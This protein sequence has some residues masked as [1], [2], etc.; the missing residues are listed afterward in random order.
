[1]RRR[2]LAQHD[3]P[4][5]LLHGRVK[6]LFHNAAQA[7]D[8]VDEDDVAP[9]ETRE[10]GG[11]LARVL[12]GRPGGGADVDSH[13]RPDDVGEGGLTKPG[14]PVEEDV[15]Y[16]LLAR[17]SRLDED[18]EVV[19]ELLLADEVI[20]LARPERAFERIV[21]WPQVRCE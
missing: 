16:G 9:G 21:L 7:M 8:F 17:Q 11:Q 15:I 1:M 20:Q 19:L 6:S 18:A 12:D 13:L 4:A 10:D 2:A 3:V 14:R 5:E